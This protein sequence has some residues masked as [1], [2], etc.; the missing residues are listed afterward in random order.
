M[1]FTDS[2][3]K[4]LKK[5]IKMFDDGWN[6]QECGLNQTIDFKALLARLEAAEKA[7]EVSVATSKGNSLEAVELWNEWRKAAG[8]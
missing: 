4:R 1:T 5:Q 7:L 2:D 8:K 3:L 6:C